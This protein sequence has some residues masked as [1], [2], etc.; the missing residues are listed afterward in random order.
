MRAVSPKGWMIAV[1]RSAGTD[2]SPFSRAAPLEPGRK[3]IYYILNR[4]AAG[5]DRYSRAKGVATMRIRG[6]TK[7]VCLLTAL[8]LAGSLAAALP[9][10]PGR[11]LAAKHYTFYL[12]NSFVGN[13][14]RVQME[15]E[16]QV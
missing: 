6:C 13:D 5:Q 8:A 14:W 3:I 10:L 16:A 9:A 15:T 2:L 7:S 4:T 11:A 1:A 12:S